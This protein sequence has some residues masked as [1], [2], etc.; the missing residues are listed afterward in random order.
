MSEWCRRGSCEDAA[1][2]PVESE[3]SSCDCSDNELSRYSAFGQ[4]ASTLACGRCRVEKGRLGALHLKRIVQHPPFALLPGSCLR[5]RYIHSHCPR[6]PSPPHR[7]RSR[8]WRPF[9]PAC[10]CLALSFPQLLYRN[11]SACPRPLRRCLFHRLP[12]FVPRPL[13]LLTSPTVRRLARPTT[14]PSSPLSPS[15][16]CCLPCNSDPLSDAK[17]WPD[18][19]TRATTSKEKAVTARPRRPQVGRTRPLRPLDSRRQTSLPCHIPP[20]YR[21]TCL[22]KAN[23]HKTA[24]SLARAG[25]RFS[26]A[27]NTPTS[28][29]EETS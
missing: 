21:P 18:A 13:C 26:S 25:R 14:P 9:S 19:Q 28:L 6:S 15:K 4:R 1:L 22:S 29:S 16:T 10:E 8:S 20:H 27:R 23:P 12:C 11:P 7:R 2:L 3:V 17:A 24:P 5:P